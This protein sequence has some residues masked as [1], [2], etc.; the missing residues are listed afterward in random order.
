MALQPLF[1][2]AR[3]PTRISHFISKWIIYPSR[4]QKSLK[5]KIRRK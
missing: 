3:F 4:L 1:V 2:F 5:S